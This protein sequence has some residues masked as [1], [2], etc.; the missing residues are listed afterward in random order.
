MIR[1]TGDRVAE[2]HCGSCDT[3]YAVD[4]AG[5]CTDELD[6]YHAWVDALDDEE[7]ERARDRMNI[8]ESRGFNVNMLNE[9]SFVSNC[10]RNRRV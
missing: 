10:V 3:R 2:I 7:M 4:L 6:A 8:A 5:D 1:V 9:R